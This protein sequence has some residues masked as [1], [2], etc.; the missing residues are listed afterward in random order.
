MEILVPRPPPEP[1]TALGAAIQR[2]RGAARQEDAAADL[3][4]TG[5]T[6]SRLERGTHRP[7]ADTARALARWLGW[8]MEQVLDAADQPAPPTPAREEG[9]S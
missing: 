7:S 2:Q 9:S 1:A 3:E 6:L 8:T 5:T 4:L